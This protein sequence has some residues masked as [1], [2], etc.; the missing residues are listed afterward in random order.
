MCAEKG[1]DWKGNPND[2]MGAEK[3]WGLYN[4]DRTPKLVM[5]QFQEQNI[6]K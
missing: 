2:M 3:H 1:E 4:V 5:R 6:V